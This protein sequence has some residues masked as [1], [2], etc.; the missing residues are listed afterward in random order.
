MDRDGLL[1]TRS[2]VFRDNGQLRLLLD[3]VPFDGE[4]IRSC[5]NTA[6]CSRDDTMSIAVLALDESLLLHLEATEVRRADGSMVHLPV[7]A[8]F[9]HHLAV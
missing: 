3:G 4:L 2:A 1:S 6:S 9:R 8:C 7:L 5:R